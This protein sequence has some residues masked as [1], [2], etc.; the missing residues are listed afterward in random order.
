MERKTLLRLLRFQLS[1]QLTQIK[2]GE[3]DRAVDMN[4][5]VAATV[6][7]LQKT[8][9]LHSDDLASLY[10]QCENLNKQI[11]AFFEKERDLLAAEHL[12]LQLDRQIEK[13]I[14]ES[15]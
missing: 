8:P 10:I 11:H 6:E 7:S 12:R 4:S 13:L 5:H 15:S 2:K 3:I 1:F 9:S 14:N